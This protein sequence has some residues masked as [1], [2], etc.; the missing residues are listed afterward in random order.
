[1][2][3]DSEGKDDVAY[4]TLMSEMDMEPLTYEAVAKDWDSNSNEWYHALIAIEDLPI[5]LAIPDLKAYAWRQCKLVDD[6]GSEVHYHWHRLVHFPSR[7]FGSWNRQ[8]RRVNVKFSLSKNMFKRIECLDHVVGVLR[9]A[10]PTSELV[11]VMEMV[12]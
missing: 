1:M 10:K 6:D 4:K 7:K 11:V 12:S 5:V 3:M 9:S 2:K 8:A